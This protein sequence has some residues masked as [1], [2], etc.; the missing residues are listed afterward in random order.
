MMKQT[1]R[2]MVTTTV[3]VIVLAVFALTYASAAEFSADIHEHI[4]NHDVTGKI[5]VKDTRYRMDLRDTTT[6]E[7]VMI[8]VDRGGGTTTLL[9]Q[10]E[11]QYRTVQN[12]SIQ[13]YMIDP[14]QSIEYLGQMIQKRK[15]GTETLAGYP[16]EKY[17][18]YDGSAQLAESWVAQALD[19]P[20]KFFIK[21]GRDDTNIKVKTNISDTKVEL[22]NIKKSPV[23]GGLFEIP[24]GYV[25]AVET[26]P[27]AKE[28]TP[29]TAVKQ[30]VKGTA[31]WG[32]RIAEGG[33]I[34]VTVDPKESVEFFVRNMITGT[35]TF[36]IGAFR[37]GTPQSI[38]EQ[39]TYSL[40]GKGVKKEILLGLQNKAEEVS[41]RT[42]KGLIYAV[43]TNKPSSFAEET[44]KGMFLTNQQRGF[45]VDEKR[46]LSI[47]ITGDSQDASASDVTVTLYRDSYRDKISE[48]KITVGNGES[49]SWKFTQQNGVKT[50]DVDV[51]RTGGI[52]LSVYQPAP[53]RAPSSR[54]AQKKQ[55]NLIKTFALAKP[56]GRG[57][58]LDT[59]KSLVIAI[60]GT[61]PGPVP[62][63]GD[64]TLYRTT[65]YQRT[66]ET[67]KYT[68][69]N[70]ETKYWEYPMPRHVG[71]INLYLVSG[72]ISVKLDQ[73]PGAK[74]SA[75]A[76]TAAVPAKKP[77][78]SAAKPV[79][80]RLSKSDSSTIIK[81]I[82]ADDTA[83]VTSYL[84]SGM[85]PNAAVYGA[86]L[87]QKAAN[88]GSAEMVKLIIA[89]GGD[90]T[91][92]NRNGNDALY[93]AMSNTKHWKEIIPVLVEAGIP[94]NDK[95]AIWKIAFK[96][97]KGTF[98]PGVKEMLEYL[99]SKGASVN[100]PIS[101][102][103][104]TLLMFAAKMA[105]LES[106]QFYLDRGADVN[107]R[108]KQG[109]TALSFAMKNRR[110]E[111]PYEQKNRQA[112]IKLLQDKGAR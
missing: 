75:E 44:I 67:I 61:Q 68:V 24:P 93:Q 46:D 54:T 41:V 17:G 28:K 18:Y 22:S 104:N 92:K 6:G 26:K 62:S 77:G 27:K 70:G 39:E 48:E 11:K 81:A 30:L 90:L 72:S 58:M 107:A 110:G 89:R 52:K 64:F 32:R 91:Y 4:F 21:S 9:Y 101:K 98:K 83:T 14:F 84:D 95:T 99:L 76:A 2:L 94:V 34:R 33:E 109:N 20:I 87:L 57:E 51:N 97:Q 85:D 88:L 7:D 103:G 10:K 96:T 112:I 71:S 53:P 15:A 3:T 12:F 56:S 25:K 50:I 49:K 100:E 40:T 74:A 65:N 59:G 108:D 13:A 63:R 5:Y 106:V 79:G 102:T 73:T 43:V 31:P 35:S 45:F 19:F 1:V 42:E 78:K 69:K 37:Q 86:P 47:T 16:C 60:T 105:W 66:I 82:N 29:L 55:T 111:Q 80:S 36:T 23:D 8:I 38:D